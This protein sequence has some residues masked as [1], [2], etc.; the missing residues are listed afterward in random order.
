[1]AA[2]GAATR[3]QVTE[4]V[5]DMAAAL[6][7]ASLVVC[8]A[9]AITCA[10][11]LASGTPSVLVPSPHVAE[12][13]QARNAEAMAALGAAVCLPEAR[14]GAEELARAIDELASDPDRLAGMR[15]RCLA[16]AAP[17]AAD[18]VAAGL[19]RMARGGGG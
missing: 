12:D 17:G 6:L 3:V 9:G 14:L 11:L 18:A 1:V 19:L 10:E 2:A 5:D 8:R 13:H 4:F 16:A 7:G 15:D